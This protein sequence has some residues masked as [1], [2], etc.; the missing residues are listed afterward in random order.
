MKTYSEFMQINEVSVPKPTK[1]GGT[2]YYHIES[3]FDEAS[4]MANGLGEFIRK[5]K[6]DLSK[7]T[8]TLEKDQKKPFNALAKKLDDF[9]DK[10]FREIYGGMIS[11]TREFNAEVKKL[12]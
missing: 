11:L 8:K 3:S 6:S 1:A 2:E 7:F 4:D 10:V 5:A 9:N 12:P